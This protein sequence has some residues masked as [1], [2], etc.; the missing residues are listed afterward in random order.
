MAIGCRTRKNRLELQQGK[1]RLEV[2]NFLTSRVAKRWNKLPRKV[3]ESPSLDIFKCR[4][5]RYLA[6]MK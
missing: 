6:G 4:L 5:V 2:R 1:I 3:G